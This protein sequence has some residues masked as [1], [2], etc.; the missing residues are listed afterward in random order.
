MTTFSIRFLKSI[1]N[2]K[3]M[4][5]AAVVG[6]ALLAGC[7]QLQSAQSEHAF[8]EPNYEF[9]PGL[10]NDASYSRVTLDIKTGIEAHIVEYS[11]ARD[12]AYRFKDG[13]EELELKLVRVH[14]AYLSK[15]GP[16]TH[17]ACVDLA[18]QN[19]DVY[20]VDYFLEGEPGSMVVSDRTLHKRNGQ[21][22]YVW[23][24]EDDNTWV[25]VDTVDA[26]P[27]LLGVV[28]GSD[29]FEFTYQATVPEI[30]T[31]GRMWI[32]IAT[33]DEFQSIQ[34]LTLDLPGTHEF[35]TDEE[36]GNK[37]L[38]LTFG[39]EDSG[40]N[41]IIRYEVKRSE[42]AV[43][44]GREGDA[45]KHLRP[46]RLVPSTDEFAGIAADVVEGIDGDLQRARALYDHVLDNMR[47]AKIGSDYGHGDA[48]YA[49]DSGTGNCTDYHSYFMALAR[50]VGIPSRFAI[51]VSIPSSRDEG[52][53]TGYHCWAEFFTEGHWWPVDISEADKSLSLGTFYFG[54]HPANRLEFSRGRDLVVTPGPVSGPINF[55]AYPVTEVDGKN[56]K[57]KINFSFE[58][59]K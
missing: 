2:P 53:I 40:K 21:P 57:A 44:E 26:S 19:G 28:K 55:L 38:Y 18:T 54:H 42:K 51:G 56:V 48:Q 32:P 58:R 36:Y 3:A 27:E 22:R 50:S 8:A 47:Y 52:G 24:Q 4:A 16:T 20:D 31:E 35:L 12:G 17:F 9:R 1:A 29:E 46:E 49:C 41:L 39:P 25:R 7:A 30:G 10:V 13:D 33:S 37:V 59:T 6:C 43:Y 23:E 11:D 14:M 45:V 34:K 15:L 5:R